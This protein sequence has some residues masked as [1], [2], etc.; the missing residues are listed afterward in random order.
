M[1]TPLVVGAAAVGGYLYLRSRPPAV[2]AQYLPPKPAPQVTTSEA[3]RAQERA[4]LS[5]IAQANLPMKLS[6]KAKLTNYASTAGSIGGA[7]GCAAVGAA[8]AAPFCAMAGGFVGGKAAPAIYS[9]GRTTGKVVTGSAKVVGKGAVKVVKAP[10]KAV[11]KV[12][13]K[14]KFW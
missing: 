9:A 2:T 7:A 3:V 14:L 12:A 11:G 6:T 5:Q 10:V 4:K 13:G 1:N 8:A